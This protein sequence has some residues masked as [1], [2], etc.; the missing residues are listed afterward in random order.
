MGNPEGLPVTGFPRES[1]KRVGFPREIM[2]GPIVGMGERLGGGGDGGGL[3][4]GD[5]AMLT[6]EYHHW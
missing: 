2:G 6:P 5:N 4:D 3:G 1:L